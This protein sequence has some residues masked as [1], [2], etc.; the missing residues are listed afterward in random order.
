MVI[1]DQRTEVKLSPD[2]VA[3]IK[4][5]IEQQESVDQY[6]W[7]LRSKVYKQGELYWND[8]QNIVWSGRNNNWVDLGS[9]IAARPDQLKDIGELPKIV[10]IYKP[11]GQ[12]II[13]ALANEVP[14]TRF[15]PADADSPNDILTSKSFTKI[16]EMIERRNNALQLLAK[17]LYILYIQDFLASYTYAKED[18]KY[19]TYKEDKLGVET[20]QRFTSTCPSCGN[21][22][23]EAGSEPILQEVTCPACGQTV[24]PIN[25][26][27]SKD[28]PKIVNTTERPKCTVNIEF[29]GP[30][31]VKIP[32]YAA[33]LQECGFLT[34]ETEQNYARLVHYY[35]HLR[36]KVPQGSYT[37]TSYQAFARESAL[38]PLVISKDVVTFKKTWLR[39]WQFEAM[40]AEDAKFFLKKFPEGCCIVFADDEY[41]ESYAECMDECWTL[42][43]SPTSLHIYDSPIGACVFPIQEVKNDLFNLIIQSIKYGIP[44][45]FIDGKAINLDVFRNST[46]EPGQIFPA[47]IPPNASRMED[48][49]AT[50]KTASLSPEVFS[51]DGIL[52]QAGQFAVGALPSIFGGTGS[53]TRTYGQAEL[54]H[55]QAL[56]RLSL[57]W[58]MI[59]PFWSKTIGKA[60]TLY[61]QHMM[62]DES[63][64]KDEGGNNFVNVWIKLSEVQAGKIG[65]I[66]PETS[67]DFPVSWFQKQKKVME[68]IQLNNEVIN[69]V[70][71]DPNNSQY[72]S[73]IFGLTDLYIP[74]ADQRFRQLYDIM[75]ILQQPPNPPMDPMTGQPIQPDPMT[76]Q[77]PMDPMTGQPFAETCSVPLNPDLIDPTV[78]VAIIRKFANSEVG[79]EVEKSNPEGWRNL[80]CRL[81]EVIQLQSQQQMADMQAQAQADQGRKGNVPPA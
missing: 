30:V 20:V 49:I 70:L 63:Y 65:E 71:F 27:Y 42:T 62:E 58:K 67:Q 41:C 23:A 22:F 16:G 38:N 5:V 12:S 33:N 72:I 13:S 75:V 40:N 34:L 25:Q 81:T 44:Q 69:Q 78:C 15:Y 46:V 53:A 80:M 76:G 3:K 59:T 2:Q 31:N 60:V 36:D 32:T 24:I 54:D 7:D 51:F 47:R 18:K 35:P 55:N 43:E 77:L 73:E 1:E 39:P 37:Q 4:S 14:R 26:M 66:L 48:A 45:S 10:Q 21:P 17:G 9:V 57:T 8:I 28:V 61:A 11:Y 52:D 56:Q 68:L 29:Y 50:L 79:M 19:G 74:G 6:N 64:V